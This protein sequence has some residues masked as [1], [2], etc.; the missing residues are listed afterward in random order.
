[1]KI[2]IMQPYFFPYIGYFQLV[3]AVDKFIFY[4]DV[5]YIKKGWINRNRILINGQAKLFTVPVTKSS[6]NKLINEIACD[7][8]EKWKIKIIKTLVYNY[9]TAPFYQEVM[10]L[11]EKI[12]NNEKTDIRISNLAAK[13]VLVIA[14]YLQLDTS[15][16]F[17]S[18][19]YYQTHGLEKAK[20]LI[21]IIK[22][23]G[24]DT[25]VNL[26]GGAELY[27]KKD[28][29]NNSIQLEF[30]KTKNVK[31]PQFIERFVPNLSIIDVLM[32]NSKQKV[33]QMLTKFS[34]V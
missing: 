20:R 17:S 6:Q 30:L 15:F 9:K 8:S 28:F 32:F 23:N 29:A 14:G 21:D 16:E 22:M 27:N 13:S 34:Y 4:D 33:R 18:D 12:L 25:Y 24:A 11:I 31:Y 2:A 26:I 1:M 5:H 19:H 10:P 3:E 7:L